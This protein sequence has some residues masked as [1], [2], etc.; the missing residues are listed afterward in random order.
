MVSVNELE[1]VLIVPC[2]LDLLSDDGVEKGS[3][4]LPDPRE[5]PRRLVDDKGAERFRVVGFES[6]D[7][8]LNERPV[9]VLQP[10]VGQIEDETTL[11]RRRGEEQS[12][13]LHTVDG[14]C[15]KSFE[16]LLVGAMN[17]DVDVENGTGFFV[18]TVEVGFAG[19]HLE[20]ETR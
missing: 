19:F 13:S 12:S 11:V 16:C 6:L 7:Q 14:K 8:E 10:E 20:I 15:A 3:K 17:L 5:D 18:G 1:Q 9:H 2:E 4:D